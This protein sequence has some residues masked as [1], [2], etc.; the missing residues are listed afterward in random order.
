MKK[1]ELVKNVQTEVDDS[2]R[3]KTR[4]RR[5]KRAKSQLNKEIVGILPQIKANDSD[6]TSTHTALQYRDPDVLS[7]S[8]VALTPMN[9]RVLPV[10]KKRSLSQGNVNENKL[11]QK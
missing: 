11:I 3:R 4:I 1:L 7:K 8:F 9:L 5:Q 6:C 2:W 10:I